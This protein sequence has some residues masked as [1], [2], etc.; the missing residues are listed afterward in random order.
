M[1]LL[2]AIPETFRY[3][4][5][6]LAMQAECWAVVGVPTLQNWKDKKLADR[7]FRLLDEAGRE[8]SILKP[9][10]LKVYSKGWSQRGDKELR[11][12]GSLTLWT[13]A[14]Y[15][16]PVLRECANDLPLT[17]TVRDL[18]PDLASYI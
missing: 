9:K 1:L 17:P 3:Q 4:A 6:Q 5:I 12:G 10:S 13:A 16:K 2:E 7:V 8:Q 18:T 11:Q 14:G 15:Q